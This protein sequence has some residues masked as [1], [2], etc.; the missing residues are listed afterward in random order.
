MRVTELCLLGSDKF[1]YRHEV[2][3]L[4]VGPVFHASP[5]DDSGARL[6]KLGAMNLYTSHTDSNIPLH[7]S[8]FAVVIF[9]L[10]VGDARNDG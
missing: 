9:E 6:A 10:G 8:R 2:A 7:R 5:R 3:G 4:N 1:V